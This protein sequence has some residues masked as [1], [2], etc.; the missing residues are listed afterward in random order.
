MTGTNAV[1]KKYTGQTAIQKRKLQDWLLE[2][3]P[4]LAG[5]TRPQVAELASSHFGRKI[6]LGH[7]KGAEIA[8][9]KTWL[10]PK[11][12]KPKKMTTEERIQDL[13][14]DISKVK[15]LLKDLLGTSGGHYQDTYERHFPPS[16]PLQR[17]LFE[18]RN[19]TEGE[20]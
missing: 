14:V 8:C 15:A 3:I 4:S 11:V 16:P 5:K 2:N 20:S 1:T 12:P 13:E 19:S 10:Q 7:I 18:T 9:D 17:P 6:T